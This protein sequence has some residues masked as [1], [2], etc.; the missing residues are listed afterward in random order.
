MGYVAPVL[1]ARTRIWMGWAA[2]EAAIVLADAI[3]PNGVLTEFLLRSQGAFFLA[4][5]DVTSKGKF[6][7]AASKK[8]A[9]A[10][11]MR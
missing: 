11:P 5:D 4:C 6:L 10:R 3:L 1:A 7:T 8:P 9:A 2:A